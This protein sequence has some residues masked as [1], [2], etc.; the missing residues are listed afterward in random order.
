METGRNDKRPSV[1]PNDEERP[2][3]PRVDEGD[4]RKVTDEEVEEFYAILRRIREA[5]RGFAVGKENR[6]RGGGGRGGAASWVPAFMWGDFE[7]GGAV[8]VNG[9]ETP[10]NEAENNGG[11]R[12]KRMDVAEERVAENDGTCLD[13]NAEPDTQ[14]VGRFK[15][16]SER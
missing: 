16:E 4:D 9:T 7:E 15:P 8:E 14:S 11:E 5:S 13:L 1:A 2:K 10:T 12:R 3:R 6:G